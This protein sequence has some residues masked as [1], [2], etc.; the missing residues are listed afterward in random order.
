MSNSATDRKRT[1]LLP[2]VALLGRTSLAVLF[3]FSGVTKLLDF[4][5]ATQEMASHHLPVPAGIAAGVIIVQLVGS[6]LL[7]TPR[8]AR[9]GAAMLALFT[10][11]ATLIAHMPWSGNPPTLELPQFILVMMN[12]GIMGGFLAIAAQRADDPSQK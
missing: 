5:A 10:V 3:L 4:P 8:Y 9:I 2:L 11:M 1:T 7:I 6:V 12:L